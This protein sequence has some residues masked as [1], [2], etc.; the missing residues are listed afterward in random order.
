MPSQLLI[1][2]LIGPLIAVSAAIAV[3]AAPR[4]PVVARILAG[5]VLAPI[6]LFCVFGFVAAMEPG[7]YHVVWQVGYIALFLLCTLAITRLA[8]APFSQPDVDEEPEE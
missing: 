4:L 3:A 5:L 6:A 8:L 1:P 7:D 2:L